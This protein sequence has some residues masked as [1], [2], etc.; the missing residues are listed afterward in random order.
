MSAYAHADGDC[1]PANCPMCAQECEACGEWLHECTCP[2]L[3]IDH[4]DGLA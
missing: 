4:E 3:P 2:T 1:W